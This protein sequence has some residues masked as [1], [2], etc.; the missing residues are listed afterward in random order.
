M[1]YL[2]GNARCLEEIL[3]AITPEDNKK[4]FLG[5]EFYKNVK[6][7]PGAI[8]GTVTKDGYGNECDLFETP[9]ES[10]DPGW[11]WKSYR[12]AKKVLKKQ[13]WKFF[14]LKKGLKIAFE[15]EM[16]IPEG[17]TPDDNTPECIRLYG[18]WYTQLGDYR[19]KFAN[20]KDLEEKANFIQGLVQGVDNIL[21]K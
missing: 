2:N 6:K 7:Y 16:V 13:P 3:A 10:E 20:K 21:D 19:M 4:F 15:H 17:I 9:S 18:E 8:I 12:E 14:H 11:A 1:N 5:L